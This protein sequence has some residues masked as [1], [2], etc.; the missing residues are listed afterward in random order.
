[1][2]GLWG[3]H[4]SPPEVRFP[5]SAPSHG[6]RHGKRTGGLRHGRR[7]VWGRRKR[8]GNG[9]PR[10]RTFLLTH[11]VPRVRQRYGGATE[12][13]PHRREQLATFWRSAISE[14][15]EG[16]NQE[17]NDQ[18]VEERAEEEEASC[19]Y[20]GRALDDSAGGSKDN[21]EY[22]RVPVPCPHGGSVHIRYM[23]ERAGRIARGHV[24]PRS[25]V[26]CRSVWAGEVDPPI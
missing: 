23:L 16:E 22:M 11:I 26:A 5:R 14:V 18:Q 13:G 21:Y 7:P 3:T 6:V 1:M 25:C 17:E 9:P 8:K 15:D 2:Q 4:Y 10:R 20:C 19:T 12:W 24:D